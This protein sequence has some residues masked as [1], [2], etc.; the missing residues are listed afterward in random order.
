ME[1]ADELIIALSL[2]GYTTSVSRLNA[3]TGSTID[4]IVEDDRLGSLAV[5]TSQVL[6]ANAQDTGTSHFLHLDLDLEPLPA[7]GTSKVIGLSVSAA[8]VAAIQYGESGGGGILFYEPG[9]ALLWA[10]YDNGVAARDLTQRDDIVYVA[11]ASDTQE[12]EQGVV[13][14][15]NAATGD[16]LDPTWTIDIEESSQLRGLALDDSNRIHVVGIASTGE[17]TRMLLGC[18]SSVGD[19]V[20]LDSLEEG[21]KDAYPSEIYVDGETVIVSYRKYQ[22]DLKDAKAG[23]RASNDQGQEIWNYV[24]DGGPNVASAMGSAGSFYFAYDLD[25]KNSRICR[26]EVEL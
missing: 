13:R 16:T 3:N 21:F 7:F 5:G 10:D 2:E 22:P 23:I 6:L 14:R 4:E 8:G 12:G 26:Y 11:G 18:L 24:V 20:F 19:I 1:N 15:L 9:G 17:E 25:L